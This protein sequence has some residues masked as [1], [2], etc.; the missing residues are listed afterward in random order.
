MCKLLVFPSFLFHQLLDTICGFAIFPLTCNKIDLNGVPFEKIYIIW[1]GKIAFGLGHFNCGPCTACKD[2]LYCL[3][4]IKYQSN[5]LYKVFIQNS[6]GW[7]KWE[8]VLI[9]LK[10]FW[11]ERITLWMNV[12]RAQIRESHF[13]GSSTDQPLTGNKRWA[14]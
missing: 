12:C 4:S 14:T 9:K 1:T 11:P 2:N 6:Q 10:D 8:N 5:K 7:E 3:A 13:R